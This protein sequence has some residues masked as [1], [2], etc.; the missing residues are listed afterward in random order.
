MKMDYITCK[1]SLVRFHKIYSLSICIL[2]SVQAKVVQKK[3][4]KK[5]KLEQRIL[6]RTHVSS[7]MFRHISLDI[8]ARII[9]SSSSGSAKSIEAVT[10]QLFY[11]EASIDPST[12]THTRISTRTCWALFN[13]P[14]DVDQI[15]YICTLFTARCIVAARDNKKKF[16]TILIVSVVMC[17]YLLTISTE[18]C[19]TS[20]F[21]YLFV[22]SGN[23][24]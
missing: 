2:Y 5:W 13:F 17:K 23:N 10:Y 20:E 19:K 21:F 14:L 22:N 24:M 4:L 9:G 3:A 8:Q 16:Y 1:I 11:Y 18:I 15:Q 12:I 6:V 7:L